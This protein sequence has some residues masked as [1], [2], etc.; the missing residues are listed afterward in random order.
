LNKTVL[1]TGGNKGIGLE[2]TKEFL[3]LG[4]KIIIIAR[5]FENF[6][7]S[8]NE[9]IQMISFDLINIDKISELVATLPDIDILINNAGVMHALPYNTNTH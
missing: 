7:F 8:Q 2:L 1:V 5:D 9:Q 4:Y 3:K 6:E